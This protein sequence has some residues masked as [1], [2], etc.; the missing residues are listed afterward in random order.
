MQWE[1]A[2]EHSRVLENIWKIS[3]ILNYYIT[4]RMA[5]CCMFCIPTVNFDR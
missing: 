2:A 5:D 3:L 4:I 1:V